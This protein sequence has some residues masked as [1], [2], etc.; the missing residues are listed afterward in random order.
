ME[1]DTGRMDED[2]PL[3]DSFG[4]DCGPNCVSGG[5]IRKLADDGAGIS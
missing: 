2:T 4:G 5:S 3:P 1:F